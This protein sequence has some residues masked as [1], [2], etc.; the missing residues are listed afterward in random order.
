MSFVDYFNEYARSKELTVYPYM[1][2]VARNVDSALQSNYPNAVCLNLMPHRFGRTTMVTTLAKMWAEQNP[3]K[4]GV[5][6]NNFYRKDLPA[7]IKQLE[8]RDVVNN[9]IPRHSALFIDNIQLRHNQRASFIPNLIRQ[10]SGKTFI[11]MNRTSRKDIAQRIIDDKACYDEYP[12]G[13]CPYHILT[14]PA[15]IT[16]KKALCEDILPLNSLP[17]L[18]K[19]LGHENFNAMYQQQ[20]FNIDRRYTKD[21]LHFFKN[22]FPE[23]KYFSLYKKLETAFNQ[24]K[25][26]VVYVDNPSDRKTLSEL[27]TAYTLDKRESGVEIK[28]FHATEYVQDANLNVI[29]YYVEDRDSELIDGFYKTCRMFSSFVGTSID[30]LTVDLENQQPDLGTITHLEKIV[31]WVL[32]GVLCRNTNLQL[33][34][35]TSELETAS[36]LAAALPQLNLEILTV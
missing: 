18:Q 3:D 2:A 1:E 19:A 31:E 24:Q 17:D 7:N 30:R 27:Y 9:D 36:N 35:F 11:F 23:V 12:T 21:S 33:A 29:N 34:F 20:V 5:L 16:S 13:D 14:L 4:T 26:I 6:V 32:S 22:R 8:T 10:L 25:N 15:Y 28:T